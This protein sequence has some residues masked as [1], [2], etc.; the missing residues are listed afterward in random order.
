[1]ILLEAFDLLVLDRAGTVVDLDAVTEAVAAASAPSRGRRNRTRL[2]GFET[3]REETVDLFEKETVAD[4][5]TAESGPFPVGWL[6]VIAGPGRGTQ[7]SLHSGLAQIGRDDD[8]AVQLDFGDAAISRSNHASVAFDPETNAFLLGHGGKSNIV[9]LNGTPLLSTESL[10]S[11]D[12]IRVGETMLRF[13][14]MCDEEFNWTTGEIDLNAAAE[15]AGDNVA[16]A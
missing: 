6:V 10:V 14:A 3:S 7:F 5:G 16:T 2:I 11:G 4:S 13:V 15:E 12:L 9:R 8:Q 1:A